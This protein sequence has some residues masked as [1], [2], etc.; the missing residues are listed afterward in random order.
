MKRLALTTLTL[1]L[2][3]A[4]G[5]ALAYDRD[6]YRGDSG[7]DGYYGNDSAYGDE[8]PRYDVAQVTAVDPI[9]DRAPPRQR[10]ECWIERDGRRYDNGYQRPRSAA[11]GGTVLGAIIGGALGNQT[12]HGDGR[13]AATIAGAVI[14]G[15]I[16]NSVAHNNDRYYDGGRDVQ[17]CRTVSD[18]D[19]RDERVVGYNVTYRYAGQTYHTTTAY[20]PGSTIRVRVDVR[21]ED[22]DHVAYR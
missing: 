10:Q 13:K 14:G 22:D 4:S 18:Y 9:L 21:A 11:N 3:A 5:S 15:A 8:G 12:G 16:G 19:D 2:V 1:A 6:A 20:H 17:R 7:Y